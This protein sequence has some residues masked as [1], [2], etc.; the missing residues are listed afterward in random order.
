MK[1]L[2]ANEK[3]IQE[4]IEELDKRYLPDYITDNL[5]DN[6]ADEH[7]NNLSRLYLLEEQRILDGEQ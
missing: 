2:Q 3:K 5:T 6:L 1:K 7:F 4:V